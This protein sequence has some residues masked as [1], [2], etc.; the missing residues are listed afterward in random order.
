LANHDTDPQWNDA[1]VSH[2]ILGP[3]CLT[4]PICVGSTTHRLRFRNINGQWKESLYNDEEAGLW[5][6][7]SSVGPTLDERIKPDI[8]A[9]GRNIISSYSSY[10]RETYPTATDYDVVTTEVNGRIYPWHAD[11][12]T[13]MS[14]P[15]VAGIIALW[16][17]AKPDL[18]RDDIMGILQRTS[19]HPEEALSY[20]NNKYGYGEIDAYRGLLDILGVTAIKEISQHEPNDARIW[21]DN[22]L[23]HL[24]F[25]NV[26][27]KPVTVTIYTTGGSIVHQTTI[28]T[29]QPNITMPLPILDKGIYI[30]QLGTSGSALIRI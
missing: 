1:I 16:L 26:P 4:A 30:V 5:S 19:R 13:S 2:N 6:P 15:V 29:S 20:P 25:D 28:T 10:Y 23:L 3:G 12:G 14:C 22:G 8:C 21:A 7:F 24:V 18:T 27:T 11:S 17:Q 9:S